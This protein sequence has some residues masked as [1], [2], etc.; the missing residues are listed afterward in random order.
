[1][2][3]NSV[4]FPWGEHMAQNYRKAVL[5]HLTLTYIPAVSGTRSGN[6]FMALSPDPETTRPQNAQQMECFGDQKSGALCTQFSV[7]IKDV[8]SYNRNF[9][10]LIGAGS[11]TNAPANYSFGRIFVACEGW[12]GDEQQI[13][14]RVKVT[15]CFTLKEARLELDNNKSI[16]FVGS[17]ELTPASLIGNRPL[18]LGRAMHA[19]ATNVITFRHTGWYHIG[20]IATGT[21][22]T[23]AAVDY[24]IEDIY[25]NAVTPQDAY[26]L[27]S[28]DQTM[29]ASTC[30]VFFPSEVTLAPSITGTTVGNA[31]FSIT[32][33]GDPEHDLPILTADLYAT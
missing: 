9:D 33:C 11:T 10:H 27:S 7:S 6:V 8:N 28:T 4:L 2:P 3:D 5:K 20:I 14:G 18:R 25:G 13:I 15:Y 31:I 23:S 1:M 30:R 32:P 22:L 17:S 24:D 19:L 29:C 26:I 16:Q 12:D 21:G